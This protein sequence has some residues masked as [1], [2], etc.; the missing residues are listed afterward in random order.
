MA[1]L[2]A[3]VVTVDA[4]ELLEKKTYTVDLV[5][6]FAKGE[7]ND[8]KQAVDINLEGPDELPKVLDP[9]NPMPVNLDPNNP[10]CDLDHPY[11]YPL[12]DLT[13][14]PIGPT[15]KKLKKRGG[16]SSE[17]ESSGSRRLL[18]DDDSSGEDEDSSEDEDE[19]EEKVAD[20]EE[21]ELIPTVTHQIFVGL[22]YQVKPVL[23]GRLVGGD[24]DSTIAVKGSGLDTVMNLDEDVDRRTFCGDWVYN[25]NGRYQWSFGVTNDAQATLHYYVK[26]APG[27]SKETYN[28]MPVMLDYRHE[29]TVAGSENQVNS[30][31]DLDTA[32]RGG[33]V[34]IS[35][36]NVV[37]GG[38]N[39]FDQTANAGKST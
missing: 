29:Y 27:S 38:N 35:L 6:T 37:A 39:V 15:D 28:K 1:L 36:D 13:E 11:A 12:F 4:R 25:T 32:G 8:I 18:S 17:D 30:R 3:A 22:D 10:R 7:G 33:Q 19:S 26:M 14:E 23:I 21:P 20:Q 31:S 16:S 5:N 2:L 34:K 24:D 9:D